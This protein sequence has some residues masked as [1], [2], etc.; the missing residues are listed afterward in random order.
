MVPRSDSALPAPPLDATSTVSG[1]NE[2]LSTP[3]LDLLD[4]PPR[5]SSFAYAEGL[6]TIG[7][8]ARI[9]PNV[10]LAERNL[11]RTSIGLTRRI[12]EERIGVAWEAI[13][14][15]KKPSEPPLDPDP[16]GWDAIRR[17]LTDAQRRI[18]LEELDLPVGLRARLANRDVVTLGHLA[19][20]SRSELLEMPGIGRRTLV[21]L[22]QRVSSRL[23]AFAA[24]HMDRPLLGAFLHAT[25]DLET[26]RRFIVRARCGL[27]GPP[28]ST[29]AIA[30]VLGITSERVRQLEERAASALRDRAWAKVAGYNVDVVLAEGPVPFA[31]FANEPWWATACENPRL[32]A[33][34]VERVLHDV[35]RVVHWE[36]AHWLARVSRVALEEAWSTLARAAEDLE[37]PASDLDI[38][39]LLALAVERIGPCRH[40][41]DRFVAHHNLRSA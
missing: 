24:E 26:K 35:A 22:P 40:V 5:V 39:T 7:D 3:L 29:P 36:G 41:M 19:Q 34:V 21:K 25:D 37:I 31:F 16:Q 17:R 14:C 4:L 27:E 12:L 28:M 23:D 38:D 2:V 30:R 11:G 10:L 1:L 18:P 15:P 32:L 33:F 9:P 6:Q 20:F 13:A 8:L